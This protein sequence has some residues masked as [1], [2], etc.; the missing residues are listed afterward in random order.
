M[1]DEPT[2]SLDIETKKNILETIANL[3]KG[4]IIIIISHLP[5]DM[6][7]CSKIFKIEDKNLKET[8]AI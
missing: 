3:K 5:E 7:I 1:F 6:K 4:K 2:S 8:Y